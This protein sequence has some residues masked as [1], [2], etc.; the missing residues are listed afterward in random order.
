MGV[1]GMILGVCVFKWAVVAPL[2]KADDLQRVTSTV[3]ACNNHKKEWC[4]NGESEIKIYS[5]RGVGVVAPS[6]PP[7][8][9]I[10]I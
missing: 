6:S 2:E 4:L 5:T 9:G 7:A 8:D 1:V 10:L 3:C